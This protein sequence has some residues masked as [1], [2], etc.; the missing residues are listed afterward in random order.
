MSTATATA[1][2]TAT[3][4]PEP[5]RRHAT[6]AWCHADFAAII[7]LIDHVDNGHTA[8]SAATRPLTAPLRQQA[9]R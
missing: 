8:L 2:P 7:D 1:T 5:S 4:L 3:R 6:C 9:T